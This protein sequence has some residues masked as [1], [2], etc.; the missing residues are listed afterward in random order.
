MS[1][2][3]VKL[4]RAKDFRLRPHQ[5]SRHERGKIEKNFKSREFSGK[6]LKFWKLIEK[7]DISDISWKYRKSNKSQNK[8][9]NYLKSHMRLKK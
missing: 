4:R 8:I 7:I 3:A 2:G 6:S 1:V 9:K 5:E